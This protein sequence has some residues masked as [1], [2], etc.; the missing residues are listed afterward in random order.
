MTEYHIHVDFGED[1]ETH[2]VRVTSADEAVKLAAR[3]K[4]R[5]KPAKPKV[6]LTFEFKHPINGRLVKAARREA[7]KKMAER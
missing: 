4:D 5:E 6:L 3:V 1:E 2:T 7:L